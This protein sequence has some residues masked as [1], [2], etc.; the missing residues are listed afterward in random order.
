MPEGVEASVAEML[1]SGQVAEGPKVRAFEEG[2]GTLVGNSDVVATNSGTGALT[3]ALYLAGVCPGTEVISTALTC[4]STNQPV[5]QL[6]GRIVW[7]DVQK[8]TGNLDPIDV[9]RKIT[10]K[11]K[12]ILCMHWAGQPC[13]LEEL[14]GIARGRGIPVIEDA[15]SALGAEYRG[16]RIG[17]Y[18]DYTCFSF[19]AVK[20][21]TTGDGGAL[22]VRKGENVARAVRLR[23]SGNDR[24]ARRTE[25]EWAFDIGEPGWKFHMNDIAATIGLAQLES[26]AGLLAKRRRNAAFF[27]KELAGVDGLQRLTRKPDRESACWIYTVLVEAR[28]SFVGLLRSHGIG[29]GIVHQ[30][31]DIHSLFADARTDLPVLDDFSSR[32]I[33]IPVG[34]WVDPGDA[35]YIV[36]V[37]KTGW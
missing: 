5:L 23:N 21:I 19:Q 24:S 34:W 37:I 32:M 18:S 26:C 20:H 1:V 7:A 6:G 33:N 2:F 36:D 25:T 13:D 14:A 10:T 3:L 4:Q 15:A 27:D 11:T 16:V 8:D 35:G 28:E 30:R 17:A 9:A 22:V 31:N 12:A 29:T